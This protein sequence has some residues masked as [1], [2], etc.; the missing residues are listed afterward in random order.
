ME[1]ALALI[2]QGAL[3]TGCVEDLADRLGVG[4]RQLSRLFK[5]HLAASPVQTAGTLRVQRAKRLLDETA[6]PMAEI[7]FRSGFRS[8]RC[9]NAAFAKLYGRPP[10]AMRGRRRAAATID[11]AASWRSARAAREMTA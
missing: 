10:S 4:P 1:R 6:L 5:Q 11:A 8:V 2:E 7:A 3:D 9:F